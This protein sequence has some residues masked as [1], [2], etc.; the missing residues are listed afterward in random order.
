MGQSSEVWEAVPDGF[1]GDA[2]SKFLSDFGEEISGRLKFRV[3][4]GGKEDKAFRVW[5]PFVH[6]M[7]ASFGRHGEDDG[8]S[9]G[10]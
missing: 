8:R 2:A 7:L 10:E 1:H 4:Q 5:C 6:G 3:L 9:V